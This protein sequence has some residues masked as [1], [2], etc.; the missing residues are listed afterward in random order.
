MSRS[1]FIRQSIANA[2]VR[3]RLTP[4]EMALYKH[5]IALAGTLETL[6]QQSLE[7]GFT[8]IEGQLSAAISRLNY[9]LKRMHDDW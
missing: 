1:T 2:R 6:Q 5:C 4:Q 7:Q 9:W 3:P 8:R